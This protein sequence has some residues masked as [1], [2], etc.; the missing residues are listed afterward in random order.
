MTLQL[1][2]RKEDSQ[3]KE[4][5]I[6]FE[7]IKLISWKGRRERRGARKARRRKERRREKGG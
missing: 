1:K 4:K 5:V 2:Q 3:H 6:N 7:V